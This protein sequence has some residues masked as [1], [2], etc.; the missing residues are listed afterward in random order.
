M[1]TL[2][3]ITL[4]LLVGAGVPAP[5][6]RAVV[7]ALVSAQVTVAAGSRS[8]FQLVFAVSKRSVLQTTLLPAGYFDP[9]IRV[10]LVATING[11]PHVLI[12]GPVTRQDM[13]P[14]SRPGESRLTV[15][16]EDI[17]HY[18]GLI[19]VNGRP[20]AAL[21]D[22]A[23][24]LTVLAPYAALGVVPAPVPPLWLDVPLPIDRVPQ[25]QGT[26]LAYLEALAAAHGYVFYI[27]PGPAPGANVAYWGPEVRVGPPQPALSIN[28]DAATNVE[29]LT[30]AYDGT[31]AA[32]IY[33][34]ITEPLTKATLPVPIPDISLLRPPLSARPATPHKVEQLRSSGLSAVQTLI[35][36]MGAQQRAGDAITGSGT[37]DVL[38][39]GRPLQARRLVGVRGAG[40][41]YDGLYYV[42]SVTHSIKRGEYKQN[43]TLARDGLVAHAPRVPA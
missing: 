26:D 28:M 24:V 32:L 14:S 39:Y 1:A 20:L 37:L 12:D 41:A 7:E 21:P 31:A 42:R 29:T 11:I 19:E 38:R 2:K 33:A 5:A 8:G 10:V 43:F 30:F 4:T 25:Q 40:T 17:A 27:E 34:W 9:L 35:R 16:G 22:L 36:G 6:P 18:M 23:K 15:T 13:A 3:G